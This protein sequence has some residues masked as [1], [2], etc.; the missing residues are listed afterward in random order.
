MVGELDLTIEQKINIAL[1]G[2]DVLGAKNLNIPYTNT[3]RILELL[4]YG[5]MGNDKALLLSDSKLFM[6]CELKNDEPFLIEIDYDFQNIEP[7]REFK[8]A[9]NSLD[10]LTQNPISKFPKNV[11]FAGRNRISSLE[12]DD[13]DQVQYQIDYTKPYELKKDVIH[14]QTS[15]AKLLEEEFDLSV[16]SKGMGLNPKISSFSASVKEGSLHFNFLLEK[17]PSIKQLLYLAGAGPFKYDPDDKRF[18]FAGDGY[19]SINA[20]R[21]LKE[22]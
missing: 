17:E 12:W 13:L 3:R 2:Y 5:E 14:S 15:I 11:S 1:R 4:G 22:F 9:V 16:H 6:G 21:G 20:L 10:N 19:A 8:Y 18:S 7:S